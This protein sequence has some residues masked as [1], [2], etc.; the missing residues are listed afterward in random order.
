MFV[1]N[2]YIFS[3][4]FVLWKVSASHLSLLQRRLFKAFSVLDMYKCLSLQKLILKSNFSRLLAIRQVTQVSPF[5]KVPGI[6][7]KVFL[8]FT[9]RFELSELL[10]F[11]YNN[12]YPK[13]LKSVSILSKNGSLEMKK[14]P[15]ISDRVWQLLVKYSLEPIYE[16]SFHPHCFGFRASSSV[17]DMQKFLSLNF[18]SSSN[19]DQ[20]RVL[21]ISFQKV[22]ESFNCNLFLQN[23]LAPRGIKVGIFRSFSNGFSLGFET[24]NCDINALSSLFANVSLNG[25]NDLHLSV[26]FGYQTLFI[27]KP[28]DNENFIFNKVLNFLILNKLSTDIKVFGPFSLLNGFTF[29]D[30]DYFFILGKGLIIRPNFSNYQQFLLRV[31]RILNNSN[32]GSN[33]KAMKLSPIIR[34]WRVQNRFATLNNS[35]FSL[36]YLRKKAFK[37]F[38]KEAKQD[39]YSV[40]KLV[41]R[42]FENVLTSEK[43]FSELEI[44]KSPYY[45]HSIFLDGLKL[46]SFSK[47]SYLNLNT[48]C[49]HCGLK[50]LI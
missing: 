6:D 7:G 15:I 44:E 9:E 18:A 35:R 25:I 21:I 27:L 38:S 47:G 48:F 32:Y 23:L 8:T 26:R 40:K 50:C 1:V 43:S 24:N 36:F 46:K 16:Y 19:S 31:K 39:S 30:W 33:I 49:I 28:F 13:S 12:W 17:F 42:C 5:K 41:E 37:V 34:E 14:L 3:S 22:F 4:K 10:R 11:N 45:G 29:L 2:V 20:K